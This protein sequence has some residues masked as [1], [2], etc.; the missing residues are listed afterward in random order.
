[1]PSDLLARVQ[2]LTSGVVEIDGGS[3]KGS[4]YATG[5]I[6]RCEVAGGVVSMSHSAFYK[7]GRLPVRVPDAQRCHKLGKI[8]YAKPEMVQRIVNTAQPERQSARAAVVLAAE[9]PKRRHAAAVE[10][11]TP[12]K[13]RVLEQFQVT[14][15]RFQGSKLIHARACVYAFDREEH[16][17][18]GS[19]QQ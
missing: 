16:C 17:R 8:M 6:I 19:P 3:V 7:R 15:H 1:M 11:P 10:T 18:S 2:Q 5:H 12:P 14:F 4:G 9:L 13:V